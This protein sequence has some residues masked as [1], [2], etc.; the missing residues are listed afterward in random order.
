M[1]PSRA[2]E[3]SDRSDNAIAIDLGVN[4]VVE[5]PI[6]MVREHLETPQKLRPGL[7]TE[8]ARVEVVE[9]VACRLFV[10]RPINFAI[11]KA[12]RLQ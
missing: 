2:D 7:R 6:D 5:H 8:G 3:Q 4:V 1:D 10:G 12:Q 9:C 11:A